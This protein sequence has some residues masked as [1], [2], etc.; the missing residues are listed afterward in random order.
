MLDAKLIRGEPERVK[1][2]ARA[3]NE[4]KADVDGWL[5]LDAERRERVARVEELK[6]ERNAASKSIGKVVQSGGDAAAEKE[7]VR[8]LGDEIA[9][10]DEA[11]R[12]LDARLAELADWFP[13]LPHPSVPVGDESHNQTV[14]TWGEPVTHAFEAKQ[15]DTLGTELG[16]FDFE[17][18]ARMSGSGFSVLTGAGA[19]LQRALVQLYLDTHTREHGYTEVAA[20][21]IVRTEAIRGTGQLPKLADDMYRT[22]DDY[23]LIPTAEVSITNVYAGQTLR[24]EDLPTYCVGYS[25]CFRRE[26]G[27]AGKDTRGMTRVHQFD[28]VEMVRFVHP[29]R[30]YEELESLTGN[31]ETLLQRLGLAY[32]VVTLASGD[33]SFAAAKCYDLEVWSPGAQRWLEV[34]SCSNFEDFQARRAGIRYKPTGGGKAGYVHTLNGSGLALPRSIIALMETHQTERGTVRIPEA[35]R[36]Y[37]GGAEEL[38]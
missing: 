34:S 20:P 14:R 21:Y 11:L 8:A 9:V 5:A 22:T 18:G 31:A 17:A 3:K 25:P 32:R 12:D 26:A 2:G 33:L 28:K 36:P 1:E 24:E 6:A 13:N 30:S 19:R 10:Q 29:E 15:H 23:W 7:R 37:L 38:A 35:L 27:A 16:W 4:T